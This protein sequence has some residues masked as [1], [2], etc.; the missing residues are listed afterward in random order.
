MCII[1]VAHR[2]SARYPLIVAANR[3][4]S[5]AR[6]TRRAG[7]WDDAPILAGRDDVAG[8]TWLGVDRGLRLAAVT[9]VRASQ[10]QQAPA[11]RSRG[12]L[13]SRFLSER[14][15]ARSFAESLGAA[16]EFAPFN[17]L[18]YD[19]SDLHYASNRARS[20]RL[21]PGVHA[22]SNAEPGAE[23]PKVARA[24]EGLA[25]LLEHPAPIE[26]L[27][28]L[29]EERGSPSADYDERQVALFLRHPVWGTRCSTV[30][31]VDRDGRASFVERSFD[32][33]GT[34]VDEVRFE[35]AVETPSASLRSDVQ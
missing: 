5:H 11:P 32:A 23:W 13:V 25:A 15:S 33:Q 3:D 29:L 24:R 4:E 9:N 16:D 7:W 8:G 20:R 27:F 22:L 34:P 1:A 30:V 19:G 18:L 17:L 10:P 6:Q 12:L 14:A 21:A 2:A 26:G 31:L 28:E 35:F